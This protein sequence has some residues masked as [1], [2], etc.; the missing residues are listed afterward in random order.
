[1]VFWVL[2]IPGEPGE[3]P[4]GYCSIP[5][6]QECLQHIYAGGVFFLS[7]ALSPVVRYTTA[8][9]EVGQ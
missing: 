5:N 2:D 9:D 7:A 8:A 3:V 1:M 4:G 6:K